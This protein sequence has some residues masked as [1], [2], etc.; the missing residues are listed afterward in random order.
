MNIRIN[1]F[2]RLDVGLENLSLFRVTKKISNFANLA[3]KFSILV[4][5]WKMHLLCVHIYNIYI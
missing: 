2:V 3:E 1:Q 5:A 4:H